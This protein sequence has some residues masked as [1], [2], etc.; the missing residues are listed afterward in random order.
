M[1]QGTQLSYARAPGQRSTSCCLSG[2]PIASALRY[3]K[4]GFKLVYQRRQT[5]SLRSTAYPSAMLRLR[6]LSGCK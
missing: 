1:T 3:Y 4:V 2:C 6:Q 5:F